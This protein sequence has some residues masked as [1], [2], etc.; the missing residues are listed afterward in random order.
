M[1]AMFKKISQRT[2]YSDPWLTLYQDSIEFSD[3][4]QGTYA[5]SQRK[6][7]VAIVVVTTDQK[8][9]LQKEFRHVVQKDSWEIPGGGI[10]T[11]ETPAQASLRELKEETGIGVSEDDLVLVGT[12][13]PLHSFN[14]EQ[15]T[16]YMA[17]VAPTEVHTHGAE[18]GE[19]I[20]EQRF[21]TPSEI[22]KMI[23]NAEI[24]DAFTAHALQVVI[25]KLG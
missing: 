21:L 18:V 10:D 7:G 17:T 15:V 25:R 16:V 23:D 14:T 20:S 22:L 13:Y 11:G 24:N 6:D 12:W 8:I 1:K 4:S 9:L 3:G 5:W 19:S 2:V